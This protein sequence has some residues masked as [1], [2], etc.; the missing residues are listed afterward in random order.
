MPG[1]GAYFKILN[2]NVCTCLP[3]CMSVHHLCVWDPL[4]TRRGHQ[5]FWNWSYRYLWA[6]LW[7]LGVEPGSL[8]E[9]PVLLITKLSFLYSLNTF[10]WAHSLLRW[11]HLSKDSFLRN[12]FVY[13]EQNALWIDS[14]CLLLFFQKLGEYTGNFFNEKCVLHKKKRL[15][16]LLFSTIYYEVHL[17]LSEYLLHC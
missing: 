7:V 4:E 15:L 12:L 16:F 17:G 1:F 11:Y 14:A 5:I 6:T 13:E 10:W 3:A 9:R 2:F 8:E